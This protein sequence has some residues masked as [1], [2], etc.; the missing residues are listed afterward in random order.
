M[1]KKNKVLFLA[2]A[3]V[4]AGGACLA[5]V[6]VSQVHTAMAAE[7]IVTAEVE[8]AV[9]PAPVE[10]AA[11]P[12]TEAT[13]ATQPTAVNTTLSAEALSHLV[14]LKEM[15]RES[16]IP[17]LDNT[18]G[19]DNETWETAEQEG[20]SAKV[21][22]TAAALAKAFFGYNMSE[23]NVIFQY[24]TDTSGHR[25]DLIK[26]I[27]KDDS[28]VCT[29]AANTLEL[30][31]IDY[32]FLPAS[33]QASGDFDF[34]ELSDSDR[35][36]AE[37][38]AAV[39]NTSISDIYATGSS[40]SRH[41]IWTK[42]YALKMK[43]GE[44]A[45]FSVMNDTLYA[46]GV[47]PSEAALEESVYFD[48]D[49]Q[50]GQVLASP[51]NFKKGEPGA[52]DMTQEEA[53]RIYEKFLA[54]ANGEGKYAKPKMTFYID[55]SGTRENYWHMEGQKLT[56]DL[57]S[58]SKQI[59]SL[60]CDNLWNP[61]YDLTKVE[62]ASMGGKEYETYVRN[63][64][65]DI[66]GTSLKSVSNNAVYDYHFCTMDAWMA[67]GSVYEFMF[68]DGRLQQVYIYTDEKYFRAS[69]SGWKADNEYINSATGEVFIPYLTEA[70]P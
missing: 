45:Q 62:Y 61:S 48:A 58:K 18:V 7:Q 35:E 36:I 43:N 8:A 4:L 24:Y 41:G 42:T 25:S 63:I 65:S 49:V 67:D 40:G 22:P 31:E 53:Q 27:T 2:V 23:D 57:S 13:A 15:R 54:L 10:L 66:Y 29:L 12:T 32:Y 6:L 26:L 33:T 5:A 11:E 38:V 56:M 34:R 9:T 17:R 1:I 50:R 47:F 20:F 44:L 69:L 14:R 30:I 64:M 16:I 19:S 37:K 21:L 51:Q 59:V 52:G 55:H 68:E 28:I 70:A 46:I 60:T 3:I 39:F